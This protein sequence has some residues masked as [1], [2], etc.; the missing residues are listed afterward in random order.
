MLLPTVCASKRNQLVVAET[1]RAAVRTIGHPVPR[2]R[3]PPSPPI[4]ASAELA[5]ANA[6]R[7]DAGHDAVRQ[8]SK[9]PID[10]IYSG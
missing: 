9:L 10:G 2:T 3:F 6:A 1:H 8:M 7:C 5:Q 4:N